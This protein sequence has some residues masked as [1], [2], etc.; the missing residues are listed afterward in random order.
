MILALLL[1]NIG[2]TEWIERVLAGLP[3]HTRRLIA[4][5]MRALRAHRPP[6]SGCLL[7]KE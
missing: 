3:E 7:N 6:R 5:I 1:V 2:N 4:Q